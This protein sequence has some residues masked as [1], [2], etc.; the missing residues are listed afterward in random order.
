MKQKTLHIAG[1]VYQETK[2]TIVTCRR[3]EKIV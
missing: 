1:T 3:N 2:R